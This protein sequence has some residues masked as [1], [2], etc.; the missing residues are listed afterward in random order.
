M[1]DADTGAVKT[2]L[3]GHEN[4]VEAVAFVPVNAVAAVRD[5][6]SNDSR[7]DRSD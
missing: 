3:R 6:V 5:L 2:E 4:V 7:Y 1:I